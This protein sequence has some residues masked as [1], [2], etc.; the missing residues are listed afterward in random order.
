M[1]FDKKGSWVGKTKEEVEAFVASLDEEMQAIPPQLQAQIQALGDQVLGANSALVK[2]NKNRT[3]ALSNILAKGVKPVDIVIPVY[4]GL[5]V[6]APCIA[7]IIQRTGW[8]Y[9][10]IIVDDATPDGSTQQWLT[11]WAKENPDHTV[12]FNKK[13]RG[14]AATVNRGIEAGENE[15]ICVLNSDVLV[16]GGWLFKMVLALETDPR[17]QIVNPCTNNTAVINI[18]MQEGYDYNDMNRAF[19]KLS[20]HSYPE[21]MPTG[22]CFF[23]PRSL[24]GEIGT[25]DEGYISYGEETDFWMRAITRIVKGQV[26]NWRAVLADDTYIFHERGTSFSVMGEEEHMGYRKSGS[27]RFH[28]IWPGF[29]AWEKSFDVRKDLATLRTPVATELIKKENPLYSICFVVYSTENCGGMKVIADIVNHLNE[30]GVAA[31]VA[32]VKRDPAM[33]KNVLPALRTEPIVFEGV[34]D[35][36][37]NFEDRVFSEG[38]VVAGTGELMP[39]VASVTNGKPK[40][41]SIHFSQSDD[42]SIAPTKQMKESIRHANKLADFTFTN[43][44]WTAKKMKKSH[45]VHGSINPGYDNLMFFPKGRETGDERPTVLVSLGNQVYPFKG[46][47]RGVDLCA[48]LHKLAKENGKEIRILANGVDAVSNAPYIVGLGILSQTRFAKVLGTEVDI[49][50]DPARNHSYGLPSLEAM[51][52]G[53]VPVCWNNKG[54]EEY[55]VDGLDAV[56]VPNKTTSEV[57]GDRIY[58]LLFNEPKRMEGLRTEGQKTVRKLGRQQG[59]LDFVKLLEEKL[60]LRFDSKRI[61]II[62][63]HLRK[64]G[65]PTTILN[66]ANLLREAGHNVALYSIHTDIDPTIQKS[67]KVPLRLDWKNIPPCDVLISNSDN[68]HNAAFLEMAHVKKK[69]MLKLSHNP[70]FQALEADSLNLKWDAIA[71]STQWLEAA[72]KTVTEG[73]EYNT[74]KNAQRVGWY[75]YGHELF[76]KTGTRRRFGN[77]DDGLTF[78]TLIHAHP[79]KGTNEALQVMEAMAKKY[80]GKLQMVGVGEVVEFAKN[81]PDWLNYLLSPSREEMASIMSQVDIWIVASHS[82]GLGRMTLEA[83]SAGCAIVSTDT[84]AE[85]L[86]DGT[87]C[88]LAPVGD[89]N[90]LTACVDILYHQTSTKEKLVAASYATA[91]SAADPTEYVKSWNKIIG[92]LF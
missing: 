7:S 1:S 80:P 68:E 24:V 89:V 28:S 92:G 59:V 19:E 42:L 64:H 39:L 65:G 60:E 71:T 72:C 46:H 49:Y 66:T 82:E 77:K 61:A 73:W 14:F 15:Y 50:V 30:V 6:L 47:D 35:F 83:M 62:T 56:I 10:L 11:E 70:R 33:K 26:T 8:P 43:S 91:N 87:N 41:T 36:V 34:P 53:A 90:G 25:F 44:K 76:S 23:M 63:P 45:K 40:L 78:G 88:L 79:L 29:K 67:C 21:I 55:A 74:H 27:S 75:H 4:G 32:H 22:F 3:I 54:I 16:T 38:I 20:S 58:S 69:I 5:H 85:F 51:A 2:S 37:N 52:S 12:L 31:K 57:L 18:P 17:N 84:G 86:R 81:K 48:H 9:K 13:N